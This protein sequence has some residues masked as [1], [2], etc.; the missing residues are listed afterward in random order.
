MIARNV[1]ETKRIGEGIERI[2]GMTER[3]IGTI[4]ETEEG[5]VG[6]SRMTEGIEMILK[7]VIGMT[8]VIVATE[9]IVRIDGIRTTEV[10]EGIAGVIE[11]IVIG[12]IEIGMIEGVIDGTVVIDGALVIGVVIEVVIG[13]VIGVV[14]EVK[15]DLM[16]EEVSCCATELFV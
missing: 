3:A 15:E 12:M 7:I 9:V 6:N 16:I 8:G 10:I 4:V 13:V 14:I 1:G 5:T 2:A 11:V